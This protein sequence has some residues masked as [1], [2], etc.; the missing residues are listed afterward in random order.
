M[1][2]SHSFGMGRQFSASVAIAIF[3]IN[4]GNFYLPDTSKVEHCKFKQNMPV[5]L[6]VTLIYRI[7]CNAVFSAHK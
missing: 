4:A 1:P 5:G 3:S 7:H 6:L 2:I